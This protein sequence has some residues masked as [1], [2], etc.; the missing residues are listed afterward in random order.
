MRA[1]ISEGTG[2][3]GF[4]LGPPLG[5]TT[6]KQVDEPK[7]N[8]Q[9]VL[10]K[11]ACSGVCFT[12]LHAYLGVS[13][14][15]GAENPVRP[16]NGFGGSVGSKGV[17]TA[18]PN[19]AGHEGSG[20][21]VEIG[22]DVP[23]ETGLRVGDRVCID[24][25]AAAEGLLPRAGIN[26][27]TGI[28]GPPFVVPNQRGHS[29]CYAEYIAAF[30]RTAVKVPPQVSDVAA[31]GVEPW[32]CG[33]RIARHSGQVLG[34]NVAVFGFDDYTASAMMWSKRLTPNELIV[35]DALPLRRE[36]A[37]AFGADHAIDPTA[38]NPVEAIRE[39]MPFGPDVVYVGVDEW[40]EP[41]HRNIQYALES[42]RWGGT[43]VITRL[44][45]PDAF[46]Y[47]DAMNFWMREVKLLTFGSFWCD[48]IW[49]G[50]RDRG[51]WKLTIDGMARGWIDP[52][53]YVAKVIPFDEL[54]TDKDVDLAFKAQ[55]QERRKVV[56]AM[57]SKD[58]FAKAAN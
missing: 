15:Y 12:D 40:L 47:I 39:R 10:I 31:A 14:Y 3:A 33:T 56:F 16:Y 21:I 45:R 23:S 36:A 26:L 7:I 4:P 2:H 49:R 17:Q 6:M 28:P 13:Q 58:P 44:Y 43:V 57:D 32:A 34:D 55:T 29:G 38:N 20:V 53:A 48:E 30:W 9:E 19:I 27:G 22:A 1:L 11:T 37:L 50:G 51:D 18:P 24:I 8:P 54:K 5:K 42:V 41:S 25:F 35:V 46:Q 52:D